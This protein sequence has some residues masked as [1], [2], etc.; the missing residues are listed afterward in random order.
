ML[1]HDL[2]TKLTYWL[3]SATNYSK[4]RVEAEKRN[5][6]FIFY[7]IIKPYKVFLQPSD[8]IL[9]SNYFFTKNKK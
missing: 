2:T 6:K 7:Y 5:T 9:S 8:L 4:E 1:I 3:F